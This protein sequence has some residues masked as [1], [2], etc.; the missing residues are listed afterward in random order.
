MLRT[1]LGRSRFR[2]FVILGGAALLLGSA[3]P[4]P[5]QGAVVAT[6]YQNLDGGKIVLDAVGDD[7]D[8]SIAVACSGGNATV[9][10]QTLMLSDFQGSSHILRC[11]EVDQIGIDGRGGDDRIDLRGVD[12]KAGYR[13][14]TRPSGHEIEL[15]GADGADTILGGPLAE[16]IG[17]YSGQHGPDTIRAGGGTDTIDGTPEADRIF[18]ESGRDTIS[19]QRGSDLADGGPDD[20]RLEGGRGED[21][22]LGRSGRD[23]LLGNHGAD[24]LFGQAGVDSLFGGPGRDRLFSGAGR[25][26]V[27]Q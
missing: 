22:L 21:R 27:V 1:A 7:A 2:I 16:D 9:N 13:F 5:A 18:G 15:N 26:H 6:A 14:F 23:K 19:T 8:D 12:P 3:L 10:D 25:D 4:A 17:V 11:R 24:T 20:D